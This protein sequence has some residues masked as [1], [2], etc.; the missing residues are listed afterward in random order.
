VAGFL[1][2]SAAAP[3]IGAG[4]ADAVVGLLADPAVTSGLASVV[5]TAVS[6][7]LAQPGIEAAISGAAGQLATAVVAGQDL[8][9]VLAQVLAGLQ[10]NT[11]FQDAVG[12]TASTAT[13]A[14]LAD[15]GVLRA[16]GSA[17]AALISDVAADPAARAALG[18]LLGAPLGAAAT[19]LLANAQVV[20]NLAAA[21]GAAIPGLVSQPGVGGALAGAVQQIA[22]AVFA[23][24]SLTDAVANAL[25]TLQADRAFTAAV[26][27]TIRS[28]LSSVLGQS[29]SRSALGEAA[30]IVVVDLIQQLGI[31]IGFVNALA[32]Q[33]TKATVSS[34]LANPS[35]WDLVSGAAENVVAGMP[36]NQV[37]NALIGSVLSDANLQTAIGFAAGQ[38]IGSLFGDNLFGNL[39]GQIVGATATIQ[40]ALVA[41][42]IRLVTG[43]KPIV[44]FGP[45][46]AAAAGYVLPPATGDLYAMRATLPAA[47]TLGAIRQN[48]AGESR[49]IL[50]RF[51]VTGAGQPDQPTLLDV[52][53]T[54]DAGAPESITGHKGSLVVAVSFR[55]DRLFPIAA[56]AS[57]ADAR[58]PRRVSIY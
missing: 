6:T 46:P 2:D 12:V 47:D 38:G 18:N 35:V 31:N 57:F 25:G 27:G 5:Q 50:D 26:G 24:D 1:G 54:V 58:P 20:A 29:D 55:L 45:A 16:V 11:A 53:M 43:G 56:P 36:L 33:L 9:T 34:L 37:A 51:A 39:V 7:L 30:S 32:G 41:A 14:L 10:S 4:I 23:G 15:A 28:L 42:V 44:V 19:S 52:A 48:L 21:L 3:V 49:F 40:L 8:Q 22:V 13:Q 17:V